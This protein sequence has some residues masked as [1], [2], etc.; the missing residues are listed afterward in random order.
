M[1][2]RTPY[3]RIIVSG[4][5]DPIHVGHVRMLRAAAALGNVIVVVNSDAWLMRKKG[6]IFM[7]FDERAEII[8]AIDGVVDVVAVNDSDGT[9]C[10]ALRRIKP[11][12]FGNGGDRTNKNTPEN[13]VCAELG[14]EMIWSLGGGKV[15]SSTDLVRDAG[16]EPRNTDREHPDLKPEKSI[17]LRDTKGNSCEN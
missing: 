9:V 4:G 17:L 2:N 5:F 10:S 16:L 12:M 13:S 1:P 14:I 7:P 8:N 6:Y 11:E 3:T 15:Q